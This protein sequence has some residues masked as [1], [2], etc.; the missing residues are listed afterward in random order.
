MRGIVARRR[1]VWSSHLSQ[2]SHPTN[3]TISIETKS[4]GAAAQRGETQSKLHTPSIH[5]HFRSSPQQETSDNSSSQFTFRPNAARAFHEPATQT[6]TRCAAT[7]GLS[8]IARRLTISLRGTQH[9][10]TP[11]CIPSH[12]SPGPLRAQGSEHPFQ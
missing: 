11:E 1:V 6:R 4:I 2:P 8:P 12:P 3:L 7:S 9:Q 5:H 10:P